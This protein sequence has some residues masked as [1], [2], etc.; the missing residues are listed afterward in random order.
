MIFIAGVRDLAGVPTLIRHAYLALD[1]KLVHRAKHD[2]PRE[3]REH[4][5]ADPCP[6]HGGQT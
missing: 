1:A 3:D 6:L 5:C 4:S 2:R